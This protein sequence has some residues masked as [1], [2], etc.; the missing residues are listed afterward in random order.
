MPTNCTTP[1]PPLK[2]SQRASINHLFEC[3][4]AIALCHNV[5][6]V[7]DEDESHDLEDGSCDSGSEQEA[8]VLYEKD[9]SNQSGSISYQASSPDEV[10]FVREVPSI[11]GPVVE[12][13]I[14]F[15]RYL[16]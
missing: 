6:P 7:L 14:A 12:Q 2:Q 10:Q 13:A 1:P 5:S 15:S 8:V 4:K 11:Q 9:R 3:V 16:S